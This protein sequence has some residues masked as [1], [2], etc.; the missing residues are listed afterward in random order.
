MFCKRLMLCILQ[1]GWFLTV[2]GSLVALWWIGVL[3]VRDNS[4]VK[5][6]NLYLSD[7][8]NFLV[9]GRLR[10]SGV[11]P[12]SNVLFGLSMTQLR[13]VLW[14]P[15]AVLLSSDVPYVVSFFPFF[16]F[17]FLHLPIWVNSPWTD[18][19]ISD[20]RSPGTDCLLSCSCMAGGSCNLR[21]V[22]MS[23]AGARLFFL[24]CDILTILSTHT[25]S[26]AVWAMTVGHTGLKCRR[27][28]VQGSMYVVI[29]RFHVHKLFFRHP[30]WRRGLG[31]TLRFALQSVAMT[32]HSTTVLAQSSQYRGTGP[33]FTV[34]GYWTIIIIS[35]TS[36]PVQTICIKFCI[37]LRT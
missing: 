25:S 23:G 20:I 30:T 17:N 24:P 27:A 22:R 5:M 12:A 28:L 37:L 15:G 4:S 35:S 13:L 9:F 16:L 36:Q 11:T 6:L 3:A 8:L 21:M 14:F 10:F 26:V 33:I 19:V 2:R 18:G 34:Q 29:F 31:R 1:K 7:Y 32:A